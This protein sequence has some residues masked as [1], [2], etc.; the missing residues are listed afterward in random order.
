MTIFNNYG[1]TSPAAIRAAKI[2]ADALLMRR[3]GYS[4]DDI[5]DALTLTVPQVSKAVRNGLKRYREEARESARNIFN[6]E[7]DRLD[8][9]LKEAL[10][11][12]R[13]G[14]K[15]GI[16]IA[17]K[18]A[19][20]RAKLLGLD[21]AFPVDAKAPA[22][23]NLSNLGNEDLA[24]LADLMAKAGVTDDMDEDSDLPATLEAAAEVYGF[25]GDEAKS[26]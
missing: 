10:S 2:E 25:T 17:L 6:L 3:Q 18:V 7:V 22:P 8:Y 19:E 11:H 16:T 12:V 9:L 26:G 23:L 14:D 15:D 4:Y 13:A 24:L 1:K 20:R 21:G 5:A